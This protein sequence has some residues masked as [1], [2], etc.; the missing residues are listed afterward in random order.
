MDRKSRN[1]ASRNIILVGTLPFQSN[2]FTYTDGQCEAFKALIDVLSK[3]NFQNLAILNVLRRTNIQ[4]KN[5]IFKSIELLSKLLMVAIKIFFTPKKSILYIT[6][7]QSSR[8][9]LRD[10]FFVAVG[11]LRNHKVY[12]HVH[13]GGIGHAIKNNGWLSR[14]LAFFIYNNANK[15]LIL[16]EYYSNMFDAINI[17]RKK[18]FVLQNFLNTQDYLLNEKII[19][20][21]NKSLR[22]L[23][24]SNMIASKGYMI[25]LDAC[26]ELKKRNFKNIKMDFCGNF[27]DDD[28]HSAQEN[29]SKFL[30][31]ISILGLEN[32]VSFHGNVSGSKKTLIFNNADFF[33]LPSAYPNE[34]IPISI[35]EAMRYECIVITSDYRALPH[36]I[37]N[38]ISGFALNLDGKEIAEKIIQIIKANQVS[39]LKVKSR[40]YFLANYSSD[41]AEEK[42][43]KIFSMSD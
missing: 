19:N 25:A 37:E 3:N 28:M 36:M 32:C 2:N 24:M 34:G 43:L 15:I 7:A 31:K 29:Q 4:N 33:L 21:P 26:Y 35:I 6:S 5:I 23:Y 20:N 11:L 22:L 17:S 16:H 13:G 30:Q 10:A 42:I 27:L 1:A 9:F 40:E 14:K 41:A 8:G 18:I 39:A 12:M 38:N